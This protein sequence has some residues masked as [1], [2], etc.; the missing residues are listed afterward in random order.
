MKTLQS[1]TGLAV[2]LPQYEDVLFF[3]H[4][5]WKSDSYYSKKHTKMMMM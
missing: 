3:W 4:A 5:L 1:N 2:I